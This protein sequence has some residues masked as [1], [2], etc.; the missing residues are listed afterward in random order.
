MLAGRHLSRV[1]LLLAL[2]LP[3]AVLSEQQPDPELREVL[4]AAA[5]AADSF[6]D[7][8][9]AEVWLTDMS[10]RLERQVKD[11]DERMRILTRVHYEASLVGLEPELV[12]AVIDVE[13]NF[14]PYAI[15]VAGAL[16]LMQVM[17]FWRNEIGRPNDNLIRLETNLRYGCTILKF[18]L[19][20]ENGDLRRALG[21]YNGSL[22]KRDYPNRVVK[23]L[24]E[25]WYQI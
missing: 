17:P 19:D 11:A 24:S 13:S 15:S 20:K 25:K 21:R 4:R 14:D 16:G 1:C 7:R 23:R 3:Q 9:H 22:G 2:W 6:D 5:S 10:R 18:Y 8:F 12:L